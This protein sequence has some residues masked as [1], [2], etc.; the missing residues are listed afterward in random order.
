MKAARISGRKPSDMEKQIEMAGTGGGEDQ[1]LLGERRKRGRHKRT[2]NRLLQAHLR[3]V[4]VEV[5]HKLD[6]RERVATSAER[7]DGAEMSGRGDDR[8]KNGA[9]GGFLLRG[10]VEERN[11]AREVS[12]DFHLEVGELVQEWK[13][14]E[15]EEGGRRTNLRALGHDE[16]V[17]ARVDIAPGCDLFHEGD[18]VRRELGL[19]DE[20]IEHLE[21]KDVAAFRKI[22]DELEET[23]VLDA[24]CTHE[25]LDE[26]LERFSREW[27]HMLVL[28]EDPACGRHVSEGFSKRG[29]GED[30]RPKQ[31][32]FLDAKCEEKLDVLNDFGG[33]A[34]WFQPINNLAAL[35]KCIRRLRHLRWGRSLH[36][37]VRLAVFPSLRSHYRLGFRFLN[38][39]VLRRRDLETLKKR[40]REFDDCFAEL[41]DVGYPFLNSDDSSVAYALVSVRSEAQKDVESDGPNGRA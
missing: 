37:H 36:G 28:L 1:C 9:D 10:A 22:A 5:Y 29:C 34:G 31:G 33:C 17:E 25:R 27:L 6:R 32:W 16:S 21:N 12:D 39:L 19:T 23:F 38:L 41:L 8:Q 4:L 7:V 26:L 40:Y 30:E 11:D 35:N 3:V 14:K 20:D 2:F 18:N 15:G 13:G 24:E